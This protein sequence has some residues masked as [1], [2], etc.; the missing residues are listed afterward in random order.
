MDDD[1][2]GCKNKPK[3]DC[4]SPDDY[5]NFKK[6]IKKAR[7]LSR[8]ILKD[9]DELEA[10]QRWTDDAIMMRKRLTRQMDQ[11][12]QT[13][14]DLEMEVKDLV[15][16]REMLRKKTQRDAL[17]RDLKMAHESLAKLADRQKANQAQ[18][19]LLAAATQKVESKLDDLQGGLQGRVGTFKAVEAQV[20]S[21]APVSSSS[22][23]AA[24]AVSTSASVS[25]SASK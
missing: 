3:C 22:S 15:D 12:K 9:E 16:Q 5:A 8:K 19:D 13:K 7:D 18:K 1:L 20:G 25:A 24:P 4:D 21:A 2:C 23:S 10:F 11:A 14:Q 17:E 6:N